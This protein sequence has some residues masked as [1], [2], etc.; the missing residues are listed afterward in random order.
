MRNKSNITSALVGAILMLP[1]M[2]FAQAPTDTPASQMERLDRG[3]VAMKQQKGIFLSWRLLGT[4]NTYTTFEVL[5]NGT[6]SLKKNITDATCY[7][8]TSGKA[9]DTYQIV[10]WQNGVAVDTTAAVTPWT[11]YY[12]PLKLNRPASVG[13]VAYTPNDCSVGDV[14][15]D[16]QYEIFVKWDPS[17]SKD[18]ANTGQTEKV[19][20]DCYK[21]DGTQLWRIDL[22]YNIRAGAHYTQFMVYDFDGDGKAEMICK[23]APGSVDGQGNFV[24]AAADEVVIKSA[25]NTAMYRTSVGRIISGPEY[26][27]VFKG[28]TGAAV[29]TI[30]YN[31]NRAGTMNQQGDHPSSKSFWN[32]DYGNRSERYLAC[33]AYLDGPDKN[34]SAVMCRGYYTRA[35]LWAVDFDGSKLKTKWLHASTSKTNVDLYDSNFNKTTKTYNS[36]TSGKGSYYTVFGCGNHNL[37]VADVDGDGCDEI[38]YGASAVDHDGN[39]LYSTGLG[40]GDAMHV[41]DLM[42]DRPGL[43]V[44]SVH[45]TN[46]NPFGYDIHDAATGEILLSDTGE[47]DCGRGLAADYDGDHRGYEYTWATQTSTRNVVDGALYS[48]N[49]GMNFRVYWDGDVL[50]EAFNDVSILKWNPTT[51]TTTELGILR[52]SLGGINSP[53]SCNGTKATPCLVADLFGD[54]REEVV[55]WS[56]T[57]SCT[58]NIYSTITATNYRVPTLM[59]D[60]VYRMGICWQNVAYNQPP[61]LGYY[62]PDY[63]DSFKGVVSGIEEV[64]TTDADLSDDWYTLQ[65]VKTDKPTRPGVYINRGRKVLVK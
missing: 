1:T 26:L 28:E 6:T 44:F 57:D 40:H 58:L 37:S 49:P 25:D 8:Y 2:L 60:H 41:G 50:D 21:L 51:Q 48:A 23:T 55:L 63:V 47:R 56:K 54:W 32:D 52:S 43:E 64:A 3:L 11:K 15:G 27:T 24:T 36:N 35:Y 13:S 22:G 59:H 9:T 33:V 34:P 62:L 30:Y 65:G 46:I 10:T 20:I 39:L 18:N 14:D 7:S 17:N 12:W 19:F 42:P 45:E 4:D 61:H 38:L 53:A 31:P 5:K 29:H 16:G